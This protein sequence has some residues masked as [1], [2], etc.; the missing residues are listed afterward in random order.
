MQYIWLCEPD[1]LKW[2]IFGMLMGRVIYDWS[3]QLIN[4]N[5]GHGQ[6]PIEAMRKVA[7]K[8]RELSMSAF[9]KWGRIFCAPQLVVTEEQLEGRT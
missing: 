5:I 9:V 7:V 2:F 8:L 6:P 3:S 1:V 4:F